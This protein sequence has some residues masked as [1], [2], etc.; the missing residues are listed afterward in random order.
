MKRVSSVR[1][2]VGWITWAAVL[3]VVIGACG[4]AERPRSSAE[5]P[6]PGA[7]VVPEPLL[8]VPEAAPP[9][10]ESS[11]H[12]EPCV[13]R[14]VPGDHERLQDAVDAAAPGETLCVGPGRYPETLT[15]R[16][17]IVIVGTG[18]AGETVV[19]AEGRGRVVTVLPGAG[20]VELQGLTLSG[21]EAEEG[22][23]LRAEGVHLR[24]R[25]VW[26]HGAAS[27]GSG[28]VH[29]AVLLVGAETV[30]QGLHIQ[31]SLTTGERVEGGALAAIGGSLWLTESTVR[32]SGARADGVL[33]GGAVFAENVQLYIDSVEIDTTVA[34]ARDAAGGALWVDGGSLEADAV[35]V[36]GVQVEAETVRG[37]GI[38]LS[39]VELGA[40]GLSVGQVTAVA[41]AELDG[42]GVAFDGVRG[43]WRDARVEGTVAESGGDLAGGAVLLEAGSEAPAELVVVSV[44]V[45][46]ST[47][48]ARRAL[49]ATV[50]ARGAVEVRDLAVLGSEVHADEQ[51]EA[52]ALWIDGSPDGW[53]GV[54]LRDTWV[55]APAADVAAGALGVRHDGPARVCN[56]V[57]AGTVVTARSLDAAAAH[58]V[59]P[60]LTA[61]QLTVVGTELAELAEERA[62]ELLLLQGEELALLGSELSHNVLPGGPPVARLDGRDARIE[63]LNVFESGGDPVG[64]HD[65]G[66]IPPT[67]HDPLHRDT[68]GSV[69]GWD[70][71]LSPRSPLVDA[72]STTERDPDDSA[73]DLGAYG[74]PGAAAW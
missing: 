60:V 47:S 42:G 10:V 29:G 71:R 19:D 25:G 66:L 72:G 57:L 48:R 43:F 14:T 44:E 2:S 64:V 4:P 33:R 46:D 52:G 13:G 37:G 12:P 65:G 59:A 5:S 36:R 7:P 11:A 40:R 28:W 26:V 39:G 15:L 54:D 68:T 45:A 22:A 49:S 32:A 69:L 30:A 9:P 58:L 31:S 35:S 34:A 62:P 55:Q 8:L 63:W 21:G 74:G 27:G 24:L 67:R 73:A 6:P 51:V 50:H 41:S 70:L 16:Q 56:M 53:I 20:D 1:E 23:A 38:A 3:A 18:G 17:S 61:C